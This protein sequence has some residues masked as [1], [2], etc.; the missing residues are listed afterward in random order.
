MYY[1]KK[2]KDLVFIDRCMDALE[3]R[4][5]GVIYAKDTAVHTDAKNWNEQFTVL[6]VYDEV[7]EILG[8]VIEYFPSV[9]ELWLPKSLTHIEI[10]DAL[11]MLL[12]K[13]NVLVR[14][15]YGSYGDTFAQFATQF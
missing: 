12:H 8:G 7:T 2:N 9:T 11:R 1:S 10:T 13:N 6:K 3:L 5:K 4:G 15:S 14:A